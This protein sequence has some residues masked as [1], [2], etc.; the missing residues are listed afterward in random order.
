MGLHARLLYVCIIDEHGEVLV[1]KKINDSPSQLLA[2]LQPYIGDIVV[3][4]E[5]AMKIE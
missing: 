5:S 4:V 2:L 1:H 3:G